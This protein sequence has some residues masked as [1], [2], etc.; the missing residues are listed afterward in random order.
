MAIKSVN[1]QPVQ[2]SAFAFVCQVMSSPVMDLITASSRDAE[3]AKRKEQSS[4]MGMLQASELAFANG[5]RV[6]HFKETEGES[7]EE[8][9]LRLEM[10][11]M[12][13]NA[14][15]A[16][17]SASYRKALATDVK[18]ATRQANIDAKKID[19]NAKRIVAADLFSPETLELK[20]NAS[21]HRTTYRTRF[22]AYLEKLENPK[23]EDTVE[24]S[25]PAEASTAEK[26]PEQ[27]LLEDLVKARGHAMVCTPSD[28]IGQMIE[29]LAVMIVELGGSIE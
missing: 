21:T 12:L 25:A 3:Q 7:A 17:M 5:G 28:K 16:G 18:G 22:I 9:A 27:R 15:E 24:D 8:K 11:R 29:V 26:T 4:A 20:K 1:T 23:V 2:D 19:K 13:D 14:I 10:S 6:A